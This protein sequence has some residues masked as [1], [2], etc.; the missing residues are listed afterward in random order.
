MFNPTAA[1]QAV[2]DF[3]I[4]IDYS[5][6]ENDK[7]LQS[8]KVERYAKPL[9]DALYFFSVAREGKPMTSGFTVVIFI[10]GKDGDMPEFKYTEK[11]TDIQLDS[12]KRSIRYNNGSIF[13]T[14]SA[15]DAT[16]TSREKRF[17]FPIDEGEEDGFLLG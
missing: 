14:N 12:M 5:A 6:A 16:N 4:I 2:K 11:N 13:I 1:E 15:V 3:Q 7:E 8:L 9:N 17:D 10:E